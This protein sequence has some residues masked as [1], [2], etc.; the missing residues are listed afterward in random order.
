MRKNFKFEGK[1]QNLLVPANLVQIS[2]NFPKFENLLVN[3]TNI[4]LIL[5]NFHIFFEIPQFLQN[6]TIFVKILQFLS[7]FYEWR[8]NFLSSVKTNHYPLVLTIF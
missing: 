7:K 5:T 4:F 2:Q 8:Q 1:F 6:F 3:L